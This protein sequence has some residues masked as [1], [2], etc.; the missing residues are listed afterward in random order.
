MPLLDGDCDGVRTSDDCDDNNP[1]LLGFLVDADCDGTLTADACDDADP[2]STVIANDADCDGVLASVDC[3]DSN[4]ALNAADLDGDGFSTCDDD[5]DDTD[6]NTFPGAAFNQSNVECLTDVDGDGYSPTSTLVQMPIT[7]CYDV[8]MFDAGGD[9]WGTN[10]L[11][12][13]TDGTYSSSVSLSAGNS[14]SAS[15]CV[16]ALPSRLSG[17]RQ[18]CQ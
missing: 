10:S 8:D 11:D 2:T 6:V 12:F 7:L 1:S 9:G 17:C 3:D 16:V 14:D 4:P 18:F 15:I 5:C 13:Y